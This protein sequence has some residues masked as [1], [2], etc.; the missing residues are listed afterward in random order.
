MN[1]KFGYFLLLGVCVVVG[2]RVGRGLARRAVSKLLCFLCYLAGAF[3]FLVGQVM[4]ESDHRFRLLAL[5]G[6]GLEVIG[7][8]SS[9]RK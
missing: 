9:F 8:A 6:L 7:I 2:Y 4:A 3:A 5:V 1:D